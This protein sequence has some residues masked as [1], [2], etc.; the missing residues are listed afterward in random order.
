MLRL[1]RLI[2]LFAV[3]H[4]VVAFVI[5]AFAFGLDFDQLRSRTWLSRSAGVI[6]DVLWFPH[7]T[8]MRAMP[9]HWKIANARWVTPSAILANSVLWG[10]AI[11]ALRIAATRRR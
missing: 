8:V 1:I 3:L 4:F 11:A 9:I 5:G 7:D 10:A 6:H 2:A